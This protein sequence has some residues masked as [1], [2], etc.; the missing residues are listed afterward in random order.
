VEII[1]ADPVL[2][3]TN[4]YGTFYWRNISLS[5]DD[6]K[7]YLDQFINALGGGTYVLQVDEEIAGTWELSRLMDLPFPSDIAYLDFDGNGA[8]DVLAA[9]S[10]SET[11]PCGELILVDIDACLDGTGS[12]SFL[13]GQGTNLL[14]RN[15]SWMS[16]GRLVYEDRI[17]NRKGKNYSCSSGN[18]QIVSPLLPNSDPVNLM[19]GRDPEG[20]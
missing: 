10:S 8:T 5:T 7:I 17:Y 20:S 4:P 18:I 9:G 1:S 19:E 11:N 14:G 12:C 6:S 15:P 3:A 16:D 2:E 13:P